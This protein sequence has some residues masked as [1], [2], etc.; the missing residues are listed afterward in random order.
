MFS[1]GTDNGGFT[2][3][4]NNISLLPLYTGFFLSISSIVLAFKTMLF[5]FAI[6]WVRG[7]YQDLDMINLW[8]CV[9]QLYYL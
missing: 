7:L 4:I 5:A 1:G 8:L 6:V 2:E 3:T 9:E